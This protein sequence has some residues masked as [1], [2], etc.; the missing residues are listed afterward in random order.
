MPAL[1][2]QRWKKVFIFSSCFCSSNCIFFH[3][4]SPFLFWQQS[5]T[6]L[7]LCST[8]DTGPD[9]SSRNFCPVVQ[10][11]VFVLCKINFSS[12]MPQQ[13]SYLAQTLWMSVWWI[14]YHSIRTCCYP[15][16]LFWNSPERVYLSLGPE[17]MIAPKVWG[18]QEGLRFCCRPA[19]IQLCSNE[20]LCDLFITFPPS[21]FILICIQVSAKLV[22]KFPR[23]WLAFPN[24]LLT[25]ICMSVIIFGSMDIEVEIPPLLASSTG[26]VTAV[27][28][29]AN[30]WSS[31]LGENNTKSG[32]CQSC[33]QMV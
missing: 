24:S 19:P 8:S 25:A 1:A 4:T 31:R 9:R 28:S 12:H 11:P 26:M 33:M 16:W 23:S 2:K 32:M 21:N 20:P 29:N 14:R 6:K 10:F 22:V 5:R 30:C 18:P 13:L 17:L 3:C 27:F 15:R 7:F